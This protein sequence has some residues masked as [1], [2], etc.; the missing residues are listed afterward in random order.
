MQNILKVREVSDSSKSWWELVANP[1]YY[2]RERVL[3]TD[4]NEFNA[5]DIGSY[6]ARV[7]ERGRADAKA[8]IRH[9]LDI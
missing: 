7:Y 3:L 1:G 4:L 6:I 5:A 9:A 8:E 2:G